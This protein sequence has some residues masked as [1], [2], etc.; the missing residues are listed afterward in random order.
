ML[1]T[2]LAS[3]TVG[4]PFVGLIA[5]VLVIAELLRRLRGGIALKLTTASAL[6]LETLD[7]GPMQADPYAFGMYWSRCK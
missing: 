2:Q 6:A 7:S 1:V 4:V 3:R 5:G